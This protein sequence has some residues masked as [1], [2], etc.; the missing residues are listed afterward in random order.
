MNVIFAF[1]SSQKQFYFKYYSES[2][3]QIIWVKEDSWPF[4]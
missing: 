4:D 3:T 1:I 2:S